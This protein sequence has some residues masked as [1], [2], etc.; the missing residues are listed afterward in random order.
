EG[1]KNGNAGGGRD[2]NPKNKEKAKPVA[3]R[4]VVNGPGDQRARRA[5]TNQ[6]HSDR[7]IQR[8]QGGVRPHGERR[9]FRQGGDRDSVT[10]GEGTRPRNNRPRCS[11]APTTASN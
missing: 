2:P 7:A 8:G 10:P 9:A 1:G 3:A 6:C 5:A 4:A 11:P